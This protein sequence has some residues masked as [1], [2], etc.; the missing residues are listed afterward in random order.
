MARSRAKKSKN[1]GANDSTT[2]RGPARAEPEPGHAGAAAAGGK[3]AGEPPAAAS[4]ASPGAGT[5]GGEQRTDPDGFPAAPPDAEALAEW[6]GTA[7]GVRVARGSEPGT[8]RA[9]FDAL[10]HSFF[11]GR[12]AWNDEGPAAPADSVVWAGRGGGKTFLG[13]VATML[14]MVFKPGIEVRILGGSLEQARRMHAHLV[15]LFASPALAGL[16]K[17]RITQRRLR[18]RNGSSVEL[19]AQSQESVRGTRVQKLRCDEVELFDPLVWDAAQLTTRSATLDVSGVG[20]REVRGSVQCF[21]TMHLAHGLM[22]RLVEEARAGARVLF[23]WGVADVLAPCTA[24]LACRPGDEDGS[25]A[26]R[27]A[28]AGEDDPPREGDCP[29][30]AE[31]RGRAKAGA[32]GHVRVSDAIGMKRRVSLATWEA[33][34]LCL[35]PSRASAVY[36]EFD[37]RLHVVGEAP[38]PGAEAARWVAGMDFGYRGLTVVLWGAVDTR[39]VLWIV[40]EHAAKEMLLED[41]VRAIHDA[42]WPRPEWI[43]V[44]P[45]GRQTDRQTGVND[46]GVLRKAGFRVI[47]RGFDLR[48]GIG[49]VRARLRPATSDEGPRLFVHR[50]CAT[51]IASLERYHY[52]AARPESTEPVKDGN[53]HA[54]DALRYMVQHLDRPRRAANGRYA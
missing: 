21:S 29:L 51:L 47:D 46:A 25:A 31:C 14:D 23:R 54:P 3:G 15:A 48:E 9:P 41:H 2:A 52:N 22:H 45:A 32:P 49:L 33:E 35:R 38:G 17:G 27:R 7:L 8:G 42:P 5:P 39:G 37:P 12:R 44:D 50:R 16:V 24:E 30:Y 34:M 26:R 4:G 43:G 10:V 1:Q 6:L 20:P 28:H 40:G 18:L 19:L 36:P 53:D 13:A 11:E